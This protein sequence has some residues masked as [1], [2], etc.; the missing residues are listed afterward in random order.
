MQIRDLEPVLSTSGL[1][2]PTHACMHAHMHA[3][4]APGAYASLGNASSA[5]SD[6]NECI[7]LAPDWAKGYG[8]KGAA[9]ILNGQVSK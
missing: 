9:L 4:M 2:P 3:Y 1:S 8:R 6:A 7:K 5:L